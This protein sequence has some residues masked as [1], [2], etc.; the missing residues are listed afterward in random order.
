MRN[1]P[2][3]DAP[4]V[5]VSYCLPMH[6]WDALHTFCGE[7]GCRIAFGLNALYGRE[8]NPRHSFN[9]TGAWDS[10]RNTSNRPLRVASRSF[11]RDCL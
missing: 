1:C 5:N 10:V 2:T 3:V 4:G 9:V 11:L 6:R 7:V 8:G